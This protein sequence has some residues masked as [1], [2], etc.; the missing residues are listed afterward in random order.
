MF[1]WTNART[2]TAMAAGIAE[3]VALYNAAYE[4]MVRTYGPANGV[5]HARA[6]DLTT[7]ALVVR[8]EALFE[9]NVE[10]MLATLGITEQ[11]VVSDWHPCTSP[12]CQPDPSHEDANCATQMFSYD[13]DHGSASAY[14]AF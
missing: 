13:A 10:R 6:L 4:R 5:A 2:L 7:F 8:E 14:P 1:H 12:L 3:V 9:R 11:P